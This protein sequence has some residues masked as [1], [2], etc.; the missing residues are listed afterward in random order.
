MLPPRPNVLITMITTDDFVPGAQTML[1]SAKKSMENN[2]K[3]DDYP[4]EFVVMV[5]PN[6]SQQARAAL[7]P[8]YCTRILEVE[9]LSFPT[10]QEEESS[11]TCHV[12]GWTA[13][14]ALTK[15]H[16]FRLSVY[17]VLLYIDA[18]CLVVKDIS[19]LWSWGDDT[20]S[21]TEKKKKEGLIAAAPDIFPPDKFNAGVLLVRPCSLIFDDMMQKCKSLISY[22]GG[23][24]GFLNAYFQDWHISNDEGA[25]R[26]LPFGYNAQR[27]LHH[28]T[29]EKQPKY[30]DMAVDLHI[31]HYSS[32]PKPWELKKEKKEEAIPSANLAATDSFLSPQDTDNLKKA[33]DMKELEATWWKWYKQSQEYVEIYQKDTA[34]A[35]MEE[36]KK[37]QAAKRASSR[38]LSAKEVHRLVAKRYKELRHRDGKNASEA[39]MIARREYRLD[40]DEPTPGSQV[41][42]MFGM[43]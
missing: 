17:N 43:G 4:P 24:T 35:Q 16:I 30:W 26:R 10:S 31:I 6:I 23:D 32:S 12:P 28:C 15:L 38:P 11:T 25:C 18:D 39:M 14:G 2:S 7:C 40:K 3:S 37:I 5:T 41:A 22:D 9:Q 29:H 21:T 36:R 27:F 42:A 19:H 20:A 1:Y 33:T 34:A 8:V 13:N